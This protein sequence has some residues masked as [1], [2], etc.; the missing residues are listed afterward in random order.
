MI[1]VKQIITGPLKENCY[2]IYNDHAVLIV[3][4][5][6]NA[7]VIKAEISRTQAKPIAVL[8]THAHH[9]HIGALETVRRQY[10]VPVYISPIEQSWLTN[11]VLNLS[12]LARNKEIADVICRPAEYE[13]ETYQTYTLG[14]M[15][16]KVVPTP[17]HSPGSMSFIFDDFVIT[18]DALFSGSIGITDLPFGDKEVLLNGIK[19][20]LFTLPDQ[21]RVFPGHREATTIGKEKDM[22]PFCN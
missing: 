4:P 22:N 14:D 17:G 16:F 18:G 9:D 1:Q 21:F 5:G 2:L 7:D 10:K 20:E 19:T 12:G 3:D 11:P 6:D 8:L 13:F 15:T